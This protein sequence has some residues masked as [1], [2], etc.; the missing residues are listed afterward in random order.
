M[1]L[2]KLLKEATAGGKIFILKSA[3][4]YEPEKQWKSRSPSSNQK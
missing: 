3:L 1:S 4:K 2:S